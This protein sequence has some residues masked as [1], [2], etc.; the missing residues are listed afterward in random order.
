MK[1]NL[2]K[3]PH[4]AAVEEQDKQKSVKQVKGQLKQVRFFIIY[5]TFS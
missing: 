1:V 5:I 4:G 2:S 3:N